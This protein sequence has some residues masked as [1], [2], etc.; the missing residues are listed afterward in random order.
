[1]KH[2]FHPDAEAEFIE[3]ALFYEKDVP[4]LG[5]RF[6]VEAQRAIE[7]LEEY[8]A[9]GTRIDM[10]LRRLVLARFPYTLI[11]SIAPNTLQI[12]AVAHAHRRPGYWQSRMNR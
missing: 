10:E 3:A 6:G 4:G 7:T 11:D 2:V 9:M 5:E 1:M 12:V 8:P